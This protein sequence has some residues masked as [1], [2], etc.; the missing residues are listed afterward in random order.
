M[1]IFK[2]SDVEVSRSGVQQVLRRKQASGS[3]ARKKGSGRPRKMNSRDTRALEQHAL[4]NRKSSIAQISKDFVPAS[5]NLVSR[6]TI[7]RRLK[8]V[9]IR[10]RRCRKVPALKPRHKAARLVWAKDHRNTDWTKIIWSDESRFCL[11]SDRPQRCLRRSGEEYSEDCIQETQK[12]NPGIMVWG[13]FSSKTVGVLH[14]VPVNTKINSAEYKN[15]L[16]TSL[17]PSLARFRTPRLLTFQQDNA[18]CHK[19]RLISD[20][21]AQKHIRTLDWPA[22]SPDLNPI[23][24]IWDHIDREIHDKTI[25]NLN[26]LWEAVLGAWNRISEEYLEV[27]INSMPNRIDNVIKNKGGHTS[28]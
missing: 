17:V 16:E 3:V 24:N 10:S 5:G 25:N 8:D 15:I 14:R 13:C 6:H 18:P 1:R 27:L 22:Q 23:E 20:W 21:L 19:T 9:G 12:G 11:R 26:E 7:S 4:R 2:K 28:Y